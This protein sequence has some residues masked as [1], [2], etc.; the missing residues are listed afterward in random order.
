MSITPLHFYNIGN[1]KVHLQLQKCPRA[2]Q[3]VTAQT[4]KDIEMGNPAAR[5]LLYIRRPQI[6]YFASMETYF[7]RLTLTY[8]DNGHFWQCTEFAYRH[9][10]GNPP[11][12]ICQHCDA[13]QKAIISSVHTDHRNFETWDVWNTTYSALNVIAI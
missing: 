9:N 5:P 8:D 3:P 11:I 13:Q 6:D 10:R 7:G 1:I 2:Q 4:W 12:D